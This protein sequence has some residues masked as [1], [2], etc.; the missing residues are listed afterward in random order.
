MPDEIYLDPA[1]LKNVKRHPSGAIHAACPACQA[2]GSDK[3]G[4]HLFIQ[5]SGKFGCAAHPGDAA[6]RKEIFRLAGGRVPEASPAPANITKPP[7]KEQFVCAYDYRDP[8]GKVI[9]QVVRFKVPPPKNKT[10]KQRQPDGKG[11][12]L[13]K[14]AGVEKVLFRLPEILHAV[15]RG[16]PV[17]LCE[18]EKDCLAM[19][20]RGF[21][22]TCNPG[23]AVDKPD[24][25]KWQPNYTQTLRG[26]DV[27]IVADKDEAGRR[28]AQSVAGLLHGVAKS[29]RVIELPD[30]N[31]QPVKDAADFFAAGGDAATLIQIYDT[32]PVWTP[33]DTATNSRRAAV[34]REYLG[35]NTR[36]PADNLPDLIDAAEFLTVPIEPP[37]ELVAG[38]LHKG[39]KLVFGG[40]SK[41]F[42]TWSLLDL[43]IS[44]A[45]GV[46]WLGR[47]TAQGRVLFV[48]FEIQPHPWQRRIAVVAQAK[49]VEIK[50]GQIVLGNYRG[51]SASFKNLIP[52]LVERCRHENFALIVLDPIYKLYAGN[53]DEN[54]AGD[55]AALLN[56]L[57]NLAEKT[58]AA[59]AF[60]AH[61]AKGNAAGKD[62]L[63]RISGSGVF[64]RDPDSLLIFTKHEEEEAF[65]VEAILRNFAPVHPFVVRWDYPLMRRDDNLDPAKLKTSGGCPVKHRPQ[66]LLGLLPADGLGN[67]DWLAAAEEKG[68]S[69]STFYALR[70]QLK[71][72][73]KVLES[74]VSGKWQPI[75]PKN[76]P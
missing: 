13:W 59:I 47:E 12:W 19:A 72:D 5:A 55:V 32:A 35:G 4:H 64:A 73:E 65:T 31:G 22:A 36:P 75:Q 6:H 44:V 62:A 70:K 21:D 66:D 69:R 52:Q 57:E 74:V 20:Q 68:M 41:S 15:Q 29:V 51:H 76:T 58:G 49:G 11:G 39:S 46:P 9:Y 34:A 38:I 63:D 71:N 14:M 37:D 28:H 48:N 54:S 42:K 2:A 53:T 24:S 18:G 8:S 40:S 56:S 50:T 43:A 61:F 23:G 7:G 16:T 30:T 1:R 3:S 60:G 33:P 26:G 17:F 10:F 25:T 45:G 27:C 67:A